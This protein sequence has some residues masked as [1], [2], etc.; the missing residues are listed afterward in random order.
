MSSPPYFRLTSLLLLTAAVGCSHLRLPAIDPSGQR[1]FSGGST[2]I[3][4]PDCPLFTRPALATT[5]PAVAAGPVVKPPCTPPVVAQPVV[6]VPVVPVVAVPLVAV[7]VAPIQQPACGPQGCPTGPQLKVCPG[8]LVAPVGSEV[9]VTAGLCGPSGYYLTKQPLEWMLA[10]DGVGQIVQVGK[11]TNN[12]FASYFRGTPHKIGPNYVRAHTSTTRQVITRGTPSPLDD[13]ALEKG[14][15]WIS[16]TSPTEGTTNITVWAPAE[17]NWE[18]RRQTATILWVD[19][20]WKYPASAIVRSGAGGRHILT[21]KITRGNG[22][23]IDNFIVEYEVLEGPEAGFGA[24]GQKVFPEVPH[25]GGGNYSAELLSKSGQPGVTTVMVRIYRPEK[26]NFRK[27]L[28]GQGL[29]S[30]TWSL[31]GL[32]VQAVGPEVV[33]LGGTVNYQVKVYNSGD[34]AARDVK[35]SFTPPSGV[36]FLNATPSPG[37]FGQMLHWRL[38]DLQPG[39]STVVDLNCRSS[40]ASDIRAKFRVESAEKLTAESNVNTKVFASSLSVKSTSPARVEVGQMVEF[41]VEVTNTGRAP[42]T[43]VTVTDNFDPGL[44]HTGGEASPIVKSLETLAPNQIR[45]FSVTFRV[46]QPGKLCHRLDVLADGGHSAATTGCVEALPVAAVAIASPKVSVLVVAPRKLEVGKK[47]IVRIEIKNG[48]SAPLTNLRLT[49]SFPK[50][51]VPLRDSDGAP[52]DDEG[53]HYLIPRMMAGETV[54][55]Q[56][57]F[58]GAKVDPT[59]RIKARLTSDQTAAKTSEATTNVAAP[60]IMPPRTPGSGLPGAAIGPPAN[61]GNLKV[62]V[63]AANEPIGLNMQVTYRINLKN[64]STQADDDVSITLILQDGLKFKSLTPANTYRVISSG[65]G[66][67]EIDPIKTVRAGEGL[68]TLEVKATGEKVGPFKFQVEVRS[69]RNPK[70]VVTEVMTRVNN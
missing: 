57:E 7:P 27:M 4:A 45:Q 56:I 14:Q 39:T 54:V 59:A 47:E 12:S 3:A 69:K 5:A 46:D 65:M 15:S 2:A 68:T 70:P 6:A 21:T 60:A 66:K 22:A 53:L 11:E 26:G 28:V 63:V 13:L 41:K 37:A 42:L 51:L 31:P 44:T 50:S 20:K 34:V 16:I 25:T 35:L 10:P 30:V 32:H 40:I 29:T 17:G 43:N 19:A 62:S 23:P 52:F 64:E 58:E 24:T 67:Y 38:G 55:K 49:A 8:Q 18:K 33:P 48:S 9:V 36:N 61:A 1:I